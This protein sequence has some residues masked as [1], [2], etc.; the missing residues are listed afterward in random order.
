MGK[1]DHMGI[2]RRLFDQT[3]RMA[4]MLWIASEDHTD[5]SE[6]MEN[7]LEENTIIELEEI[8]GPLPEHVIEE[9]NTSRARNAWEGL[10]EYLFDHNKL[11]LLIL[12]ETPVRKYSSETSCRLSWGHYRQQWIY[13]DSLEEGADKAIAWAEEQAAKDKEKSLGGAA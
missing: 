13:C 5:P 11:G 2:S 1:I 7:L 3:V 10:A 8:F 6:A 12:A 9:L 4:G